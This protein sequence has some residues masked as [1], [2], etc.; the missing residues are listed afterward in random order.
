MQ[1]FLTINFNSIPANTAGTVLNIGAV[2]EGELKTK[3]LISEDCINDVVTAEH[4][5]INKNF[6]INF[7]YYC[8]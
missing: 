3:G 5:A 1:K 2:T 8:N 7:N 6:A 4:K